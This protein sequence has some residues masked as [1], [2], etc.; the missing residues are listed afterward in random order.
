LNVTAE[1]YEA[2]VRMSHDKFHKK[3]TFW[4][5]TSDEFS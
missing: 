5:P 3:L 2:V 1:N 4:M